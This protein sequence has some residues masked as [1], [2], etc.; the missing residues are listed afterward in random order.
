MFVGIMKIELRFSPVSSLKDKRKIINRVKMKLAHRFK[1]SIAE[2]E[3]QALYNSSVIGVAF[4]S[5]KR[6]HAVSRCQKIVKFLE[7]YE[8]DVFYDNNMIIE[9]Y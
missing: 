5:L 3:D 4:I 1:I 9:E 6:N 8:S 2:V 7:E